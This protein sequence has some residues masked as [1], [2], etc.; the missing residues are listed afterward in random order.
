MLT[1]IIMLRVNFSNGNFFT[2]KIRKICQL[3]K[4]KDKYKKFVML[5]AINNTLSP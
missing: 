2:K 4:K 1:V 5:I 3:L